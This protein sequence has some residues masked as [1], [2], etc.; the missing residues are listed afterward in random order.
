MRWLSCL[1]VGSVIA[2]GGGTPKPVEKPKPPEPVEE[3]PVEKADDEP[4]DCDPVEADNQSPAL[5]FPQRAISEA[6]KLAAEARFRLLESENL[7]I[8]KAL[9]LQ[10]TTEA[11][12]ISISALLADPYN[13]LATYQL[14]ALYARIG[15]AQC[16][17]NLLARL[18]GLRGMHTVREA[19]EVQIDRL[20]GRSKRPLDPDFAD[21]RDDEAFRTVARAMTGTRLEDAP[22]ATSKGSTSDF[23]AVPF[24]PSL[25]KI[26]VKD[27]GPI[28]KSKQSET[29]RVSI[30]VVEV[31]PA[32]TGI[33]LKLDCGNRVGVGA[34]GAISGPKGAIAGGRVTVSGVKGKECS[35]QSA[36][37]VDKF[38]QGAVVVFEV[39]AP[40]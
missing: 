36:L 20:L 3:K 38:P 35:A 15:R 2:C 29:Q 19:T 7:E 22:K 23:R 10:L 4:R 27:D 26:P 31:R 37:A 30:K 40:E 39:A 1:V 6:Q 13:P 16:A 12:E 14:A 11:V 17:I 8:D 34:R 18:A 9:K 33:T 25:A 5:L 28:Q 32:G 21:M 24:P